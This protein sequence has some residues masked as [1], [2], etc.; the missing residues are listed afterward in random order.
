MIFSVLMQIIS[1]GLGIQFTNIIACIMYNLN[2]ADQY[3]HESIE[4]LI[5][6]KRMSNF[7]KKLTKRGLKL[8]KFINKIKGL[9]NINAT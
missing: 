6:Q 1:L 7:R 4:S 5:R 9:K 2:F 3:F 8:F